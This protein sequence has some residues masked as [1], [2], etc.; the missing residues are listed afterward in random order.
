MKAE[1]VVG[2]QKTTVGKIILLSEVN[3]YQKVRY[4]VLF[5]LK[6]EGID[7]DESTGSLAMQSGP[8]CTVPLN[9]GCLGVPYRHSPKG[10]TPNWKRNNLSR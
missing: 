7:P 6:I 10:D 2:R 9:E 8:R 5:S 4:T 1:L 3:K